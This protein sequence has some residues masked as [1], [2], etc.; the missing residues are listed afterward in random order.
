MFKKMSLQGTL[1]TFG[2]WL[3]SYRCIMICIGTCPERVMYI[4]IYSHLKMSTGCPKTL[5]LN[6]IFSVQTIVLSVFCSPQFQG[7]VLFMVFTC[8]IYMYTYVFI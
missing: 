3:D 8:R 6:G 2:I 5:L 7:T 1:G 4:Y